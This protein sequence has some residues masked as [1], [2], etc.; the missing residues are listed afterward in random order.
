MEKSVTKTAK[1]VEE[2]IALAVAE[3]GINEDDA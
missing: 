3:L 2:A 1:S